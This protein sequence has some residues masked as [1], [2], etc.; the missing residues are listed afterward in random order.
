MLS[1]RQLRKAFHP[2]IPPVLAGVTLDV[3]AGQS[4]SIRGASGCGKSSLLHIIAGF[5]RPDS[6]E[7]WFQG[8]CLTYCSDA[9]ADRFR[10]DQLGMLFQAFNLFDALNVWDNMA[11]S[12]R[13]KG[14]YDVHFHQQLAEQLGIAHLKNQAITQLSGGEQQRV[15]LGR[16]LLTRPALILADEPTGNLDEETSEHIAQLLYDSCRATNAALIVVTHSS[17]IARGA[18]SH[19]RLHKGVLIGDTP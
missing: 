1:L 4:V 18:D 13:L 17:D 7:I 11:F 16:A 10:R 9:E 8:R 5:D 19:Y 15:A 6:G 12:A 3:A 2:H 14:Q